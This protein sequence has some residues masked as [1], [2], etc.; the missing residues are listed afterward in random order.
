M[1]PRSILV[2]VNVADVSE[3]AL[4]EAD[5]I[6]AASGGTLTLVHIHPITQVVVL[7]YTYAEPPEVVAKTIEVIENRLSEIA[8]GL[9]TPSDRVKTMVKTGDPAAELIELTGDYDLVVMATHGRSGVSRFLMGSVT[10]RVVRGSK[11]SVLSVRPP[12]G[13]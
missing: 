7:D 11:C 2:P 4:E 13:G 10:E 6:A 9:E 12:S 8:S 5:E 1:K 3:E